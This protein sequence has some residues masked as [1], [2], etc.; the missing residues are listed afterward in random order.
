MKVVDAMEREM[1]TVDEGTTV[2]EA[3]AEISEKG[4]GCAIVLSKCRPA[5][6]LTERDVTY[7]VAAKALNAKKVT[8]GEIMSTPLIEV[9]PDADLVDAARLMD[10]HKIRRLAVVRQAIIYGVISALN[11]ARNLEG[12][13]DSE[14]RKIVRYAFFVP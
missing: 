13:V 7:K 3:C 6:M 11:I 14:V 12:C 9:D 2:A 4:L 5:G 1:V 8:A 10:T